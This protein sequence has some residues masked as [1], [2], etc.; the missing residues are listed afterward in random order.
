[1]STLQYPIMIFQLLNNQ[2]Y[3]KLTIFSLHSHPI[4]PNNSNSQSIIP[5]CPCTPICML[6]VDVDVEFEYKDELLKSKIC[7]D[8]HLDCSEHS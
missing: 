5:L 3:D 8:Q 6:F 4:L 2:Y 1:M 7:P